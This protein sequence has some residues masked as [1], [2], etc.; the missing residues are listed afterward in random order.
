[1]TQTHRIL[2]LLREAGD[3]GVTNYDLN[4]VC[5]RYGARL[6]DLKRRGHVIGSRHVQGSQWVFWLIY[7]IDRES[8]LSVAQPQ[9]INP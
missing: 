1:M 4:S 3:K 5:F 7:D 9:G 2:N 6:F 8:S